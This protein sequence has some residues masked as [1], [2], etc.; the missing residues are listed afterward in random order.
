MVETTISMI[1]LQHHVA[2]VASIALLLHSALSCQSCTVDGARLSIAKYIRPNN[3]AP[4]TAA[5]LSP[6][7]SAIDNVRVFNRYT[8][9]IDG[10]LIGTD[11]IGAEHTDKGGRVLLLGFIESHCH[12]KESHLWKT[13][14][15][16][17]GDS[18]RCCLFIP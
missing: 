5:T 10:G 4:F 15:L 14:S 13:S 9:V 3:A 11:P 1:F 8:I 12:R 6:Q 18:Y 2:S 16:Q 7:K 17:R